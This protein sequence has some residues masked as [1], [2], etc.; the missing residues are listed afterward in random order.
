[1]GEIIML[2]KDEAG[3]DLLKKCG[4]ITLRK[5]S[6]DGLRYLNCRFNHERK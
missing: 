6:K 5:T 4:E 2:H 1:M 3:R